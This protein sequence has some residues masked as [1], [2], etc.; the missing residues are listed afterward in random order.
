VQALVNG[1]YRNGRDGVG[2]HQDNE[3]TIDQ[4]FPIVSMSFG[5]TRDFD[6]ERVSDKAK[7]RYP[8]KDG[9]V[10]IMMPG[11]QE[12]FKHS[13]PKRAGTGQ[14]RINITFRVYK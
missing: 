12:K 6:V 11:T 4:R 14:R 2:W 1:Y 8:L 9:D 13:V 5:D 3:P 10:V 7:K